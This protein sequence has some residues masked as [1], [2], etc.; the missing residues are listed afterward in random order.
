MKTKLNTLDYS[1]VESIVICG[2]TFNSTYNNN[3]YY[4]KLTEDIILEN[5]NDDQTC[6]YYRIEQNKQTYLGLTYD[7]Y[8]FGIFDKDYEGYPYR[9]DDGEIEL[10]DTYVN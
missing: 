7:Q 2:V 4:N 8:G 6:Y 9:N 3:Y 1:R 5:S 10:D